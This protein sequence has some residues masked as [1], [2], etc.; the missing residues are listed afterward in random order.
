MTVS[1]V[2][3]Q[4]RLMVRNFSI[5]CS[6]FQ[7][8]LIDFSLHEVGKFRFWTEVFMARIT[9]LGMHVPSARLTHACHVFVCEEAM[10]S[11]GDDRQEYSR[12]SRVSM[13]DNS[14]KPKESISQINLKRK[15]SRSRKFRSYQP[16][17]YLKSV[18]HYSKSGLSSSDG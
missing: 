14:A 1:Q 12:G 2:F 13:G 6:E 9:V 16:V 7:C 4:P 10:F 18:R 8:H 11:S 17:S 3:L 15:S 5:L